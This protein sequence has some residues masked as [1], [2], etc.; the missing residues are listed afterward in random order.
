MRY[1]SQQVADFRHVAGG[2][3]RSWTASASIAL[4]NDGAIRSDLKILQVRMFVRQAGRAVQDMQAR[5]QF[6]TLAFGEDLAEERPDV[7][8]GPEEFAAFSGAVDFVDDAP[9]Q[10]A[11]GGSCSR[12]PARRRADDASPRQSS[13]FR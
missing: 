9:G 1:R 11:R 6:S 7:G 2:S 3:E 4:K 5:I 12:C 10:A 13:Q 8:L